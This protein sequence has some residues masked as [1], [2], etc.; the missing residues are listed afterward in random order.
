M[1]VSPPLSIG[2]LDAFTGPTILPLFHRQNCT[3]SV[4]LLVSLSS[5]TPSE[6]FLKPMKLL[7]AVAENVFGGPSCRS[8]VMPHEHYVTTIP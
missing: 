1:P 4:G 5:H 3:S 8:K 2:K 6:A 7:S